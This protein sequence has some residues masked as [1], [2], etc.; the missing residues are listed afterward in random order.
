MVAFDNGSYSVPHT[1]AGQ[2]VWVR[3]YGEQVVIVHVGD[4][5]PVEVARHATTNPG[6]R[7]VNDAHFPPQPEGPLARSPRAKTP[8]E[9]EFLAL[10][11]EVALWLT[12]AAAAGTYRIRAK[13]AQAV[14]LARL[15]DAAIVDRA[16]GQ[17]ATAAGFAAVAA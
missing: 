16:L 1:L 3:R 8:A 9:T 17:A 5:G 12:E 10:G 13:M 6:N 4:D 14:A 11:E 2:T 15:H 7:Q